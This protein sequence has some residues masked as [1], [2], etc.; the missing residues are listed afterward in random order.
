[1]RRIRTNLGVAQ[2]EQSDGEK[3]AAVM[4]DEP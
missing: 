4:E 2:P 1:M 3:L